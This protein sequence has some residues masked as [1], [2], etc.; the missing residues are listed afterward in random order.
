MEVKHNMSAMNN[1][2]GIAGNA[3]SNSKSTEKLSSGYKINRAADDAAGL[4]I[5]EKMRAQVSDLNQNHANVQ[6]GIDIAK[7]AE[8]ALSEIQN[9]LQR[10]YEVATVVVDEKDRGAIQN[11]VDQLV[12]EIDGIVEMTGYNKFVLLK[13]V[14]ITIKLNPESPTSSDLEMEIRPMYTK[15]L[16]VK[17]LSVGD[18][19]NIQ[20]ISDT[21]K[22]AIQTVSTQR[23]TVAAFQNRLE[24]T[25]N[26]LNNVMENMQDAESRIRDMSMAHEMVKYTKQNIIAQAGKAMLEQ[27][28]ESTQG[29]LSLLQ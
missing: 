19:N 8:G 25:L 5:S 23:S 18:G 28:N 13:G 12:T 29:V 22:D 14:I 6:H 20:N 15:D 1:N 10:M 2:R 4:A 9:I 11:E 17:G 27:E 7:T 24:H 21:I 16:G 26:N 3:T